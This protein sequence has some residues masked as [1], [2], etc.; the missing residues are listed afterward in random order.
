MVCFLAFNV[1]NNFFKIFF[2]KNFVASVLNIF[3]FIFN[4]FY[5]YFFWF[6]FWCLHC[7]R[8]IDKFNITQ[9]LITCRL[10]FVLTCTTAEWLWQNGDCTPQENRTALTGEQDYTGNLP[11]GW[12]HRPCP[13]IRVPLS[14]SLPW[15]WETDDIASSNSIAL[16]TGPQ[17]EGALNFRT[18]LRG[19]FCIMFHTVWRR[20]LFT[21]S[22]SA[23]IFRNL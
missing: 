22:A 8:K 15:C 1:K 21:L 6:I 12:V 7:Y 17:T 4:K 19:W 3:F 14:T 18:S 20:S 5:S 10:A 2:Q 9:L 16:E 13:C 11:G 23:F